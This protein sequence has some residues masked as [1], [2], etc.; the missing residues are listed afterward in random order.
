MLVLI[1]AGFHKTGT[2]TVQTTL[3]DNRALL[4]PYMR[5]FLPGK[6]RALARATRGYSIDGNHID[7]G[8]IRYE[9]AELVLRC[10]PDDPRPVLMSFEDLAGH[11]P[12]RKGLTA[13]DRTPQIMGLIAEAIILAQPLAQPAFYFSTRDPAAWL[14]SCYIQHLRATRITESVHEYAKRMVA[15]ADLDDVV[16]RVARVVSPVPVWRARLTQDPV[17]P[18]LKHLGV[19]PALFP[20]WQNSPP[21]FTAPPS[22]WVDA[23]LDLNRSKL[24][25]PAWKTAR[26][27]LHEGDFT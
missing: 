20:Q 21:A 4:K 8:M 24:K 12:G 15:S 3:N 5:L 22:A 26:A 14:K 25:K 1:H 7:E 11:M 13:Y 18:L 17:A 16:D 2:T 6:L 10:D 9:A 19:Q 27:A 23:V